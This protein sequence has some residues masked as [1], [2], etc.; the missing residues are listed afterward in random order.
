MPDDPDPAGPAH[1]PGRSGPNHSGTER[2]GPSPD[3][4][5]E[6]GSV[7]FVA[8]ARTVRTVVVLGIDGAGKTTAA[9]ALIAA[10]RAAGREAAL[11]RNP[12]GR[13]WLSRVSSRLGVD[14]PVRWRNASK[15][16]C[17]A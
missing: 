1:H 14:V 4:T 12:A 2:P 8:G 16:S 5:P 10:E 9:R 7:R 17:A 13:R 11:V 6:G 3:P 15:R